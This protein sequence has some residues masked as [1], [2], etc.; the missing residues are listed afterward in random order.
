MK[1]LHAAIAGLW[2]LAAAVA[3]HAQP[4]PPAEQLA[5][6]NSCMACHGMVHKQV[7][8]GFAEIARR[9]RN[10]ASLAPRLAAKIRNGSVGVWGRIVMPRQPQVSE[11]EALLLARWVL[12]QPPPPLPH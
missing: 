10:D 11:E 2:C 6:K 9:Y 4:V 5:R 3:A 12:S 7:G 1:L 8:P